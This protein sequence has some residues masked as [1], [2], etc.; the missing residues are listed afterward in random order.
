MLS[1]EIGTWN[2]R[3]AK[4]GDPVEGAVADHQRYPALVPRRDEPYC[5]VNAPLWDSLKQEDR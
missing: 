3:A 5:P 4:G 2:R 1:I